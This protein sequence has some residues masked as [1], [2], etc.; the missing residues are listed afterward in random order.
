M[1]LPG[2]CRI[3][4]TGIRSTQRLISSWNAWDGRVRGHPGLFV[5]AILKPAWRPA[6]FLVVVAP[7][8]Q[9]T[10]GGKEFVFDACQETRL[11][12][13][14]SHS[15]TGVHP[16]QKLDIGHHRRQKEHL[17]WP[18]E[19]LQQPRPGMLLRVYHRVLQQPTEERRKRWSYRRSGKAVTRNLFRG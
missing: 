13:H 19:L 17:Q 11:T 5:S 12:C 4:H 10:T 18:S 3:S 9:N 6:V 15:R 7:D 14:G 8:I 2:R 16:V 1:A